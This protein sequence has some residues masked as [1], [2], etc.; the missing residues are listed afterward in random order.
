MKQFEEDFKA[1]LISTFNNTSNTGKI[2]KLVEVEETVLPY[3]NN[4]QQQNGLRVTDV[5][6]STNKVLNE[7]SAEYIES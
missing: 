4:Y 7:F 6:R 5:I 2:E 1:H 3:I